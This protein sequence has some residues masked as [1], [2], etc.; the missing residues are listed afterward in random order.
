MYLNSGFLRLFACK[1]LPY[2]P[3]SPD[4]WEYFKPSLARCNR[5]LHSDNPRRCKEAAQSELSRCNRTLHN[6]NPKRCKEA[7]QSELSRHHGTLTPAWFSCSRPHCVNCGW[8]EVSLSP[9]A[10]R[11][12][13][14]A[15]QVFGA[16]LYRS[17][18]ILI[19]AALVKFFLNFLR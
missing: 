12:A 17:V 13:L 18:C 19:W 10:G 2:L 16:A 7:A 14:A 3:C 5:M 4:K 8:K 9:Y 6:D 15:T 1:N 11:C